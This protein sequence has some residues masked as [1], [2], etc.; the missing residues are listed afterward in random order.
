ME[1]MISVEAY[2]HFRHRLRKFSLLLKVSSGLEHDPKETYLVQS[3]WILN[4]KSMR[5]ASTDE[6]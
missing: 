2:H 3:S 5:T 1:R 6:R 4:K